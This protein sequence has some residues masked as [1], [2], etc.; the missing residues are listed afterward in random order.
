MSFNKTYCRQ[1]CNKI[2]VGFVAIAAK[3]SYMEDTYLKQGE[4]KI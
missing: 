4:T 3:G 1:K 2:T